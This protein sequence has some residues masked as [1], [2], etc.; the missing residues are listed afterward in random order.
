MKKKRLADYF[1]FT[2]LEKRACNTLVALCLLTLVLPSLVLPLLHK[3]T[4]PDF[5]EIS[6]LA[7]QINQ[8]EKREKL[9]YPAPTSG[10]SRPAQR[11]RFNPST[12]TAE[13][14][15][16]LGLPPYLVRNI[17]NYRNRG[18]RFRKAEDLQKIYGMKAGLYQELASWILIPAPELLPDKQ[19]T[20]APVRDSSNSPFPRPT[21]VF[22]KKSSAPI[23]INSAGEAEWQ[24]LPGIGAGLARRIVNYRE[25]LGGFA[26]AQQVGETFGLP[27]STFRRILPQ[28]QHDG[29]PVSRPLPVNSASLEA[30]KGHPY[31]SN[32]QATILFNYRKQHGPFSGLQDLK[33]LGA[34]FSEK[35]WKR[36]EPYLSFE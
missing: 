20:K 4:S 9:P 34:A 3:E 5:K 27:D 10:L 25:K 36:L 26:A 2:R 15:S 33:K 16:Q 24:Q 19:K 6:V 29:T 18:G 31:L 32:L 7:A 21:G 14:L 28:L 8:R 35:D 12:A 22:A 1:Y 13:E 17:V 23:D 11:F 30:L